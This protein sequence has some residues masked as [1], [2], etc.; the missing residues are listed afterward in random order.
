M[1]YGFPITAT[2]HVDGDLAKVGGMTKDVQLLT[3]ANR[4]KSY[5]I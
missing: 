1:T 5:R 3:H 4:F 2:N